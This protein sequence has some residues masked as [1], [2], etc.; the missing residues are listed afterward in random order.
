M[1]PLEPLG[2][3]AGKRRRTLRTACRH[4]FHC[5]CVATWWDTCLASKRKAAEGVVREADGRRREAE[6][7]LVIA[8]QKSDAAEGRHLAAKEAV[9]LIEGLLQAKTGG[10]GGGGKANGK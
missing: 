2:A 5:P 4:N 3:N 10:G 9:E 7:R 6:G 8:T 1:E